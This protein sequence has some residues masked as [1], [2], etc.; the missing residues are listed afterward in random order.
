M[1]VVVVVV[2]ECKLLQPVDIDLAVFLLQVH[3]TDKNALAL[4]QLEQILLL[5]QYFDNKH[6]LIVPTFILNKSDRFYSSSS[7]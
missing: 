5:D 6:C 3:R 4:D 1:V 2:V 7:F